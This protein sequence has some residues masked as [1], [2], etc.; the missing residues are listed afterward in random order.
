MLLGY[1]SE[2]DLLSHSE[3]VLAQ[4][5]SLTALPMAP[6]SSHFV[7]TE[8]MAE[9]APGRGRTSLHRSLRRV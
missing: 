4:E 2:T 3:D 6:G 8:T 7:I 1:G 5:A 9:G